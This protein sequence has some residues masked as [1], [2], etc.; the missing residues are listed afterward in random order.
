MLSFVNERKSTIPFYIDHIY[1]FFLIKI[2][3][4]GLNKA[5]FCCLLTWSPKC[6]QKLYAT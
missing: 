4:S 3:F 5:A 1:M 2:P 6:W